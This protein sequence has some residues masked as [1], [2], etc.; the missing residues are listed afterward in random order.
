MASAVPFLTVDD[1]EQFPDDGL[2]RE[3]IDGVLYVSAAPVRAHQKVSGNLFLF[4]HEQIEGNGWGEVYYSP[5]DVKFSEHSQ[6][7]PDLIVLRQDHLMRY[8]GHTV[9]GP[10][11]IVVEILSPSNRAYD[12]VKK[13]RLYARYGVPEYWIVD[14]AE[15]TFQMRALVNGE[16]V[17]VRPVDGRYPSTVV[18]HLVVDPEVIFAGVPAS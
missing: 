17:S 15:R 10:P 4:L 16:Y 1:L 5:V 14:Q 13:A 6:V 18:S 12:Q 8:Q 11:D 7:Q 9:F 2:R 3:I